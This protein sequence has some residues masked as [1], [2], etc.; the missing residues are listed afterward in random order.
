MARLL[1]HRIRNPPL[2]R[3]RRNGWFAAILAAGFPQLPGREKLI[4]AM[5]KAGWVQAKAARLLNLTP[6]Q[7]AYKLV[8]HQIPIKKF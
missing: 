5:E 6:R 4:E 2:R 8:K 7:I 1:K 3:G